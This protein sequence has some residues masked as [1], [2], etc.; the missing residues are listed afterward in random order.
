MIVRHVPLSERTEIGT[1]RDG[2]Q[3]AMRIE[4]HD[5]GSGDIYWEERW[6]VPS[7]AKALARPSHAAGQ[8]WHDWRETAQRA[9]GL[10]PQGAA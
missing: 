10:Q 2:L 5:A 1:I 7:N 8:H 9:R 4:M 6:R 3:L